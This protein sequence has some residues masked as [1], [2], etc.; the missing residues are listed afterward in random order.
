MNQTPV[1]P[2]EVHDKASEVLG[3]EIISYMKAEYLHEN[4]PHPSLEN[5]KQTL[6]YYPEYP[7][8]IE[9]SSGKIITIHKPLERILAYNYHAISLLHSNDKVIGVAHSALADSDVIPSLNNKIDIG[10]GG[11][12]EPDFERILSSEPDALLSYSNLGPG[13]DFFENRLPNSIPVI[14]LDIIRPQTIREEIIKLGYLLDKQK[15]AQEYVTWYDSVVNPI[16]FKIAQ[17][18]PDKRA[19]V[20]LDVWNGNAS[21]TERKTNSASDPYN[22]YCVDAGVINIA[23]HAVGPSGTIDTE[24]IMKENPDVILGLA[25]KGGYNTDN[26]TDLKDQYDEIMQLPLLQNSSAI[27]NNRVYIIGFRFTN[28]PTYP[29][30]FATMAKWMYPELFRDLNPEEIHQEY[31]NRFLG[32]N[33]TVSDHGVYYYPK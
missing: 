1:T 2:D 19:R 11:P 28:G 10:G 24:W 33:Y 31:V 13:K 3:Q 5:F 26:I 6:I 20:F 8:Q 25:Y 14:R 30:A 22:Q 9:D 17:I 21:F 29:A 4:I 27:R 15:E 23:A 12:Y 32:S 18:P 16:K 7:R